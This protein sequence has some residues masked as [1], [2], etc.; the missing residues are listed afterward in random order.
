MFIQDS[1]KFI[2]DKLNSSNSFCITRFGW[3]AEPV[4]SRKC[5]LDFTKIPLLEKCILEYNAGIY[6]ITNNDKLL[7]LWASLY[8]RAIQSSTAI[9]VWLNN[10]VSTIIK[11]SQLGLIKNNQILLKAEFI[12]PQFA[13]LND[14]IPWTQSLS[15]KKVLIISPFI[16]SFKKQVER[17]YK[18][19]NGKFKIFKDDQEF[20]FYKCYNT[21]AGNHPH[22]N[23]I[24]TLN[25]MLN[26]IS[27]LDFDIALVSCGGYGNLLCD[28]IYNYMNKSSI[29]VGGCLQMFFGVTCK[30]Y[31][32][33]N[34]AGKYVNNNNLI[35]PCKNEHI[36]IKTFKQLYDITLNNEVENKCY[37]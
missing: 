28:F 3:G 22:Y 15:G 4:I 32:D 8:N 23:W 30:R 29:Y 35:R 31:I 11:E 36:Q 27:K 26:D 5:Q 2:H 1:N 7:I 16:E 24:I 37:W 6:G 17:K 10:D 12:D 21:I 13:I 33:N 25:I 20:V 14:K 34:W 19:I 18:V 9:G